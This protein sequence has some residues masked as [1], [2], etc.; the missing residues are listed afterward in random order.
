[1]MNDV[2]QWFLDQSPRDQMMLSAGAIAVLLYVLLFMVLMPMYDNLE[3]TQQ[4]NLAA[5]SE[6]Q[7]V[8]QLAGQVLAQKQSPTGAT[9]GQNLNALLNQSLREFGL[10]MENFQPSGDSARVRLGSSEF[11]KVLAWLNEMETKQGVQIKDLTITADQGPG[12]VL[13]NL[14]LVRGE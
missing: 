1:M 3:R 7:R 9:S 12:A 4:R 14:Q 6:Q 5:M 8:R 10:T 11:N 13:V 2:K